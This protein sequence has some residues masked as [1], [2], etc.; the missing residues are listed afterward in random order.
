MTRG[1]RR[2]LSESA[3]SNSDTMGDSDMPANARVKGGFVH[4]DE[5]M[6]EKIIRS[7]KR[8]SPDNDKKKRSPSSNA[9]DKFARTTLQIRDRIA[10]RRR[11]V[12]AALNSDKTVNL[13]MSAA[14]RVQDATSV[15]F[16]QK[17]IQPL[18]SP[19]ESVSTSEAHSAKKHPLQAPPHRVD[20]A[21]A[22]KMT[23][24]EGVSTAIPI[25]VI[26]I[27]ATPS[28]V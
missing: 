8:R 25:A 26:I 18:T 15:R 23:P 12:S 22:G 6:I 11:R 28:T 24:D 19:G 21:G 4:F 7:K 2:R 17:M 13:N 14:A 27:P 16:H 3:S 10:Q 20:S 5:K 1:S 9:S